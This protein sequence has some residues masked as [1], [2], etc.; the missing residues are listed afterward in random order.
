MHGDRP[1]VVTRHTFLGFMGVPKM[2]SELRIVLFRLF[3]CPTY[4][5][6]CFHLS[7]FRFLFYIGITLFVYNRTPVYVLLLLGLIQ[8]TKY[9]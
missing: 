5:F 1:G 8:N 7:I 4:P 2:M 9:M 3:S 6:V